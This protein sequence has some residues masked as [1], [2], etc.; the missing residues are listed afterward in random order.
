MSSS[1]N[2]I[3][4]RAKTQLKTIILPEPDDSRIQEAARVIEKE[5][6][7]HILLLS[8]DKLDVKKKEEYSQEFFNLRK[9]RE[10]TLDNARQT[11]SHPLY[12]AAMM[13]REH[14]ADGFIAGASH[15]TPD[16]ARAAI[17]CLGVDPRI[18]IASSCF[19]MVLP[20]ASWGENG[21]FVF[22]DCGIVPQPNSQQLASIAIS[23]ADLANRVLEISPYVA[24]LSYSTKGSAKGVPVEKVTKAVQIVRQIQPQLT[25][26][27]ELQIDAAIVPEVARTKHADAILGGK[28]NVLI[29]PCLDAGN[30]SYKLVQRLAG[31]RAIGPIILG[32]NHPCSDLSRGCSV[33]DVVDCVAVTAVRAQSRKQ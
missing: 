1:I 7:A 25:V 23:A 6:I 18:Q 9:H 12:Y 26:D 33:D 30:I 24:L 20:E 10:I 28:A 8:H 14:S 2:K 16:V 3:R 15:T 19:I 13:V 31:A 22:A 11:M 32:L 5:R 29:F 21:V 27:G 17:Y 4:Q